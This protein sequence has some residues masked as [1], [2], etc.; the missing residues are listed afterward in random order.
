MDTLRATITG[1]AAIAPAMASAESWRPTTGIFRSRTA[2]TKAKKRAKAARPGAAMFPNASG[3]ISGYAAE[4]WKNQ[5]AADWRNRARDLSF[6]LDSLDTLT[7][8]T[9]PG[10]RATCRDPGQPFVGSEV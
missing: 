3:G 8:G 9:P 10:N 6:V 7:D 4:A 1:A 5:T 2:E